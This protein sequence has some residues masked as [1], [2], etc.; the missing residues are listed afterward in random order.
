M[1]HDTSGNTMYDQAPN[2]SRPTDSQR[3][4]AYTIA[5]S[6][7][8]QGNQAQADAVQE[9]ERPRQQ[10]RERARGSSRGCRG[11]GDR[12]GRDRKRDVGRA[13][14]RY[15]RDAVPS[16]HLQLTNEAKT[17]LTDARNRQKIEKL[18]KDGS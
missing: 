1:I 5:T 7:M 11:R 18:P 8:E 3:M 9:R 16:N 10:R 14:W 6:K 12:G 4:G 17:K 2:T 15:A 13:E